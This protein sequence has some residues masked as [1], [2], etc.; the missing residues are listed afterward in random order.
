MADEKL[1]VFYGTTTRIATLPGVD[2]GRAY[3]G[4]GGDYV[5][6]C[7]ALYKIVDNVLTE[8]SPSYVS[9][10][11][12]IYDTVSRTV[13]AVNRYPNQTIYSEPSLNETGSAWAL[14]TA[15][16]TGG[17]ADLMSDDGD[18]VDGVPVLIGN[19]YTSGHR[20]DKIVDLTSAIQSDA[21]LPADAIITDI[22]AAI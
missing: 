3:G 6:Q 14:S 11:T 17:T 13:I 9:G 12:N 5:Y 20:I 4:S 8:I 22:E 21:G 1:T 15:S 7:N 2:Y 18:Q 10:I 19:R 16:P